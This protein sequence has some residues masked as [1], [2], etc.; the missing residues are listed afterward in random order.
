[1][2][3]NKNWK[4]IKIIDLFD[5]FIT[6]KSKGKNKLIT[7]KTGEINYISATNKNNG[8]SAYIN[9]TSKLNSY[10]QNGNCIGFI[11]NGDGSAGFAIYKKEAFISTSDVTFAYSSWLNKFTGLFFVTA[12]DRIESKYGHGYKRN[13]TH[14]K[15]DRVMLPINNQSKPDFQYMEQ[16]I[17]DIYNKKLAQYKVYLEKQLSI[18]DEFKNIPSLSEKNWKEFQI[19]DY[20]LSI[21]STNSGI[22]ENKLF[23][24]EGKV[25]YLTRKGAKDGTSNGI[26]KYVSTKNME[27][28]YNKGNAISIGLDTQTAF[29]QPFDFITGQN[30]HVIYDSHI[31]K[32]SSM[33]LIPLLKKQMDAK[34]NWGGNG[35]TLSR[36]KKLKV[37]LPVDDSGNPDWEYMEQ[38]SKNIMIKKYNKYL[39]YINKN[40]D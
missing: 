5:D 8:V 24:E 14:L 19:F 38:Y 4:D 29:Y 17:K 27:N 28:G 34:F 40:I 30:I 11:K 33:F 31:N 18:L 1:M 6:G 36:M 37:L 39:S 25:P 26:K 12:Q 9:N 3:S 15:N 2:M 35:A 22:D 21:E 13:L 23:N 16:Y 32:Y 7:S 10:I 20:I